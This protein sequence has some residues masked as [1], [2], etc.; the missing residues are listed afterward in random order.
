[1]SPASLRASSSSMPV[2]ISAIAAGASFAEGANTAVEGGC[3]SLGSASVASAAFRLGAD[4]G[5]LHRGGG[6]TP[7]DVH[8]A[9]AFACAA[10]YREA[11]RAARSRATLTSFS[12]TRAPRAVRATVSPPSRRRTS[13]SSTS[14]WTATAKSAHWT[15][16]F[17]TS[18]RTDAS[19]SKTRGFVIDS[20]QGA[21]GGARAEGG[22]RGGREQCGSA[23]KRDHGGDIYS[24]Q[25]RAPSNESVVLARRC[26][27]RACAS[28]SAVRSRKN[29][30]RASTWA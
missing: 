26:N 20:I 3:S 13:G 4:G 21:K 19:A 1:M 11:A 29:V 17:A 10:A 7:A 16:S 8:V 14:R 28:S 27:A 18:P 6:G 2:A 9:V 24:V 5:G 25:Q 12:P 15:P 22:V 30:M 23:A